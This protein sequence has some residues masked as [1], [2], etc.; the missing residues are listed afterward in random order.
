MGVWVGV[1]VGGDAPPAVPPPPLSVPLT[2]LKRVNLWAPT[3][4]SLAALRA[5][6]GCFFPEPNV[7]R[8]S[9]EPANPLQ[10]LGNQP[11]ARLPSKA[12]ATG[13]TPQKD[14]PTPKPR[15]QMEGCKEAVS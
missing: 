7:I 14:M 3:F 11:E 13:E 4:P 9:G 6:G 5:P 2:F 12:P 8:G 1:G 15:A 10:F